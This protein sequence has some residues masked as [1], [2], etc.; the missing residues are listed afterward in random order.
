MPVV[1]YMRIFN[2]KKYFWW[3][4]VPTLKEARKQISIAKKKGW[5]NQRIVKQK[6]GIITI[7][8]RKNIKN[9]PKKNKR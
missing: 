6:N 5:Q 8:V 1:K 9:Y 2:K 4:S 3:D 7:W